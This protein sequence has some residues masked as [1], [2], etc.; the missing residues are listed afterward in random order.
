MMAYKGQI[1]QMSSGYNINNMNIPQVQNGMIMNMTNGQMLSN[2]QMQQHN[3]TNNQPFVQMHNNQQGIVQSQQ[4]LNPNGHIQ[5]VVN[6]VGLPRQMLLS[7]NNMLLSNNVN[8]MTAANSGGQRPPGNIPMQNLLP[9]MM[10]NNNMN[11]MNNIQQMQQTQMIGNQPSQ[12]LV[13]GQLPPQSQIVGT[14]SNGIGNSKIMKRQWHSPDHTQTRN[15][16]V[17]RIISLLKQRRPNATED[18]HEKL[19]HMAKRLEE[20]LYGQAEQLNEYA[21]HA[22]LKTRLQQLALSMGGKQAVRHNQQ[23]QVPQPGQSINGMIPQYPQ[24][25]QPNQNI[26]L[27]QQPMHP[28]QLQQQNLQNSQY[29]NPVLSHQQ[30]HQIQQIQQQG[31]YMLPNQNQGAQYPMQMHPNMIQGNVNYNNNN[32]DNHHNMISQPGVEQQ[33]VDQHSLAQQRQHQQFIANMNPLPNNSNALNQGYPQ[34]MIGQM[35]NNPQGIGMMNQ[36]GV[37]I[38]NMNLKVDESN[39]GLQNRPF[40]STM[41]TNQ[42]TPMFGGPVIQPNQQQ[43]VNQM[44]LPQQNLGPQQNYNMGQHINHIPNQNLM[45]TQQIPV[46]QPGQQQGMGMV[47]QNAMP[48]NMLQPQMNPQLQAPGMPPHNPQHTEEHRRQVLKQQQQRLLLLRH[49]SKCPH[50][51]GRCPVTPHCANMKALWKHI[52][53]CKDQECKV[54]HCVSSRYVL[55]HYSKC[56]D[57]QCP[58]CGPVREAIRRNYERSKEIVEIVSKNNGP[59]VGRKM[60]GQMPGLGHDGYDDSVVSHD[61]NSKRKGSIHQGGYN[62]HEGHPQ[63]LQIPSLKSKPSYPLDPVSCAIYSFSP[64]QIAAHFKTI[65]EGVRYS[66][67]KIK[68][69]F[70]PIVDEILRMPNAN[71][72]FGWPVDPVALGLHDYFDI[73]KMPM[74]LGTIRKKLETNSYRDVANLVFDVHLT[75]N[76]AV[77]YNPKGS[78]VHQLAKNLKKEFD[79]KHKHTMN[80]IE[81]SI[82]LARQVQDN[83]LIC[84]EIKLLY[85]PPVYYCNGRCGGQRIR[86][87]AHF[88][89]TPTNN[90]HWCNPCYNELRDNQPIRLPDCTLHKPDLIKKKHNEDSEE[91]WVQC[92]GPCQRWVH[93]ICGLFNGRR[94]TGDDV[95]FVCPN[96][97]MEKRRKAAPNEVIISTSSKKMKA[98][99]L[100]HCNMSQF[101]EKRI[102]ERLEIAYNETAQK[103]GIKYEEVE[104]CPDI[105]LRQVSCYDKNQHV[106]EGVLDR[107]K[108]K[109]YPAE[110]P[111]RTKC[112]ILFQNIDGQDV[113]LFGMYVYEYGHKCPQPNQRRVYISYLDSVHYFRPKQYRTLV[114]HEILISYLDYVKARGF[115]TAHI[116]ACPP[117][118]G[119]DYILYVHPADQKTPRPDKLRNWYQDMLNACQARGI[120]SEIT[121]IHSEFLADPSYDATVLPYFEGDYWVNEAEVIIKDLN[122]N[123]DGSIDDSGLDEIGKKSKRKSKT[124]RPTRTSKQAII[125]R[126]ERDSLMAK[127]AAVIEPMRDTFFVARLHSREYAESCHLKRQAEILAEAAEKETNSE[128]ENQAAQ[129][130][131]EEALSNNNVA[132]DIP[133]VPE[134]SEVEIKTEEYNSNINQS[135]EDSD[136]KDDF[137]AMAAG[138]VMNEYNNSD[139]SIS[140]YPDGNLMNKEPEIK[141]ENVNTKN[142]DDLSNVLSV[143]SPSQIKS[144]DI[145]VAEHKEI[146]K[147]DT[148]NMD[149]EKSETSNPV[150]GSFRSKKRKAE[151]QA[152]GK[153]SKLNKESIDATA[154]NAVESEID[155]N[156]N[157]IS[158]FTEGLDLNESQQ[159]E[160]GTNT[161]VSIAESKE[162][163]E[164]TNQT[165]TDLIETNETNESNDSVIKI[166]ETNDTAISGDQVIDSDDNKDK[167][168]TTEDS[169]LT[170]EHS[171]Y[172]GMFCSVPITTDDTEDVDDVQDSEHFDTRQSVLNFV[173][174]III[175]STNL[176]ELNIQV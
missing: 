97:L 145:D 78:D 116:W 134:K 32:M 77:L 42:Q 46:M 66:G 156:T 175:N 139:K 142:E 146:E 135:N 114:Y 125:P 170:K 111:C 128:N 159:Y 100:P 91:P 53:S 171:S 67:S 48:T 164:S 61:R 44:Q 106:R 167:Q 161:A 169:R 49:A 9:N 25:G 59:G 65:H 158:N 8:N 103:R 153:I 23:Q 122:N 63:T 119:D 148:D 54:P 165:S 112:V 6:D 79:L 82:E 163:N 19:P 172:T 41:Q 84:G 104:K 150:V 11:A 31:N 166:E 62:G 38:N 72:V 124:K 21:D 94:N 133:N 81:K 137:S 147:S 24:N 98:N 154:S 71:N 12:S 10:M 3:L 136:N 40:P 20:A 43:M 95:H 83:C 69:I 17:E 96:C 93:Q 27:Q 92:D 143:D 50:E 64:E 102:Y 33:V 14:T 101:I 152:I 52:M 5:P 162:D 57:Q 149:E 123:P 28:G 75:F 157:N 155:G 34:Q 132:S 141:D 2:G 151:T 58:V 110:F 109:N 80:E 51:A 76:N 1:N 126:P 89:S 120:V 144:G 45:N 68:E 18:W 60:S 30:Q 55:S 130:L 73:I 138:I 70:L 35:A 39:K 26:H 13:N 86:R 47:P 108:H 36:Q 131:Q 118:K 173:K 117:Q 140:I 105:F 168:T 16:M 88:Y 74:D 107:Y 37:P 15:S 160:T 87:S 113:I 4:H 115:H 129:Q 85:E 99:D 174:V 22:T 127:L 176:E 90:Y 29:V 7:Q 121:D 56:K